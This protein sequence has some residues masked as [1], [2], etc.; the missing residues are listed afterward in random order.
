MRYFLVLIALSALS[1]SH[2]SEV[3]KV[4]D[5]NVFPQKWQLVKMSGNI[6][7]STTTGP[8]ME[9]QE[10]YLFNSDG[11]FNRKREQKNNSSFESKGKYEIVT[12]SDEAFYILTYTEGDILPGSC[13]SDNLEHLV[14]ISSDKLQNTWAACDGPGLEYSRIE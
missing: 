11:T 5:P 10:Q 3:Q 6:P 7:N 2:D 4:F 13:Y 1:C 12:K 9:W 8:S 14:I